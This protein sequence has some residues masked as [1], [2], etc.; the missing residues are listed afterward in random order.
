[1]AAFR[2]NLP[3]AALQLLR[4]IACGKPRRF[5]PATHDATLVRNGFARTSTGGL[6]ITTLGRAKLVFEVTR[7]NWEAVA[8]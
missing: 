1:M 2:L 4:Q 6:T 3:A 8:A 7:A 5:V